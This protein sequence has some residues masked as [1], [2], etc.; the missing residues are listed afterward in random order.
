MRKPFIAANWKMYKTVPEAMESVSNLIKLIA[1]QTRADVMIAPAYPLL[2]PVSNAIKDD[3]ILLSAQDI[4]WE[5]EGAYTGQVS[6]A[7]LKSCGC[8]CVIVGHSERRQFFHETDETVNKKIRACIDSGFTPVFCIGE[9]DQE[10]KSGKT[11]TVLDKQVKDGLKNFSFE[12]LS[13]LVVA[14][15]PVWAIGTGNTADKNDA[16]SAH[17]HIRNILK[18]L[19][20]EKLSEKVRIL[21]GG[22]VKPANIAELM[23]MPDIDGALVGGASLNAESFAS[24]VLY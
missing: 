23:Q 24:I 19:F 21:Y 22:S 9:T 16:Q 2:Y 5:K 1:G 13:E 17:A 10:R 12:D 6:A 20:G 8:K 4:Y 11:E 7:M 18:G 15:E 3:S 14:Y